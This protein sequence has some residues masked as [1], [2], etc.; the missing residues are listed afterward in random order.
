MFLTES[1]YIRFNPNP[2]TDTLV[3]NWHVIRDQ[4]FSTA[5]LE[6]Q[7]DT[8]GWLRND[9]GAKANRETVN[10][11]GVLYEGRFK[12]MSM[13]LRDSI[14]DEKEKAAL[15]WRD[16][17]IYRWWPK[18]A[19]RMPWLAGYV[20]EHVDHIAGVTFNTA[21]PGS[22]LNHHWGL[23]PRYLRLHLCL[24]AAEGCAFNIEGWEHEWQDG[25]LFAFDDANV[26]HGT[27]HTGTNPRSIL[28][29]DIHKDILRPYAATWPCRDSR[30]RK[31]LWADIK[32]SCSVI[33]PA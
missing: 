14:T 23:D 2:Y 33:K 17:E 20:R 15:K 24:E 13:F 26:L 21:M 29:I 28:L 7:R 9:T 19:E 18:R 3:E 22:T 11:K 6:N 1:P 10:F 31:D 32:T 16:D 12:S 25:E 4:Y 27:K 30:P 5:M 8:D